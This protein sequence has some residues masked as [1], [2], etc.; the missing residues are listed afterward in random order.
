MPTYLPPTYPEL[1]TKQAWD[2]KKGVLAKV[3]GE[4]GVGEAAARTQAAFKWELF[5][6]SKLAAI[7]SDEATLVEGANL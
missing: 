5:D 7:R 1:I 3:A 4:T 2:R 6:V